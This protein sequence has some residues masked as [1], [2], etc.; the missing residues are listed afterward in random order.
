MKTITRNAYAKINLGLDVT[1]VLPNGYHEVKMIMQNVGICDTLTFSEREDDRIVVETNEGILPTDENNLVYKAVLLLRELTGDKRGVTIRLEKRI[2]I[3]AGMAGG[4]TDAAATL[5]GV[6]ELLGLGLTKNRLQKESVRIGAD[7]PYCVLGRTALSEGIGEKLTPVAS[8]PQ[9]YLVVAKPD[10][11]VST[12]VVY[13]KLDAKESY[14]HPD[15]DGMIDALEK[16]DLEGI[17]ARLGNVL[18]LVTIEDHPIVEEIKKLLMD[19]GALG[20]LMSGSG[21]SVFAIFRDE[22]TANKAC[23]ALAEA[24]LAKQLFVT[25]FQNG[26][27]V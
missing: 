10:I 3:A 27:N 6:N 12:P 20:A 18:E 26:E 24:N 9:A 1:G 4:S 2:P 7:V 11:Y 21:P 5:L 25:N 8:P 23:S 13:K 15:I 17:I 22:E 16:K 19:N 14:E